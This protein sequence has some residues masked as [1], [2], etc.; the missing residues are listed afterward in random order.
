MTLA[1]IVK[2]LE[3]CNYE[4]EA[5][6]LANNVAF[7]ALKNM[8]PKVGEEERTTEERLV[9][10]F[11]DKLKKLT[12]EI[13]GQLETDYLPYIETNLIFNE[14]QEIAKAIADK[15]RGPHNRYVLNDHEAKQI[16]AR[17]L[18]EHRNEIITE[19]NQ[20]SLAEIERLKKDNGW[21]RQEAQRRANLGY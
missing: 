11:A 1:E 12:Y 2:Q 10:E 13:M 18:E 21:Y 6:P 4:C 3:S 15:W 16:R 7:I 17:I 19:L 20:D 8:L 9:A 5:G 14:R